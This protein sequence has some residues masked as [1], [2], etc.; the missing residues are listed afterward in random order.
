M[1]D[2][3]APAESGGARRSRL[4]A[5]REEEL[6]TAVLDL[7]REVGY[8]A[9]T[10][11]AVATRTRSSKATLYRQ[12]QGKPRLV[13]AALRHHKRFAL[14]GVDTGSLRG[15]LFEVARRIGAEPQRRDVALIRAL[16]QAVH[17]NEELARAMHETIIQPELEVVRRMLERAVRRGEIAPDNP[18]ADFVPHLI[19]GVTFARPVL[20]RV[21][22]DIPYLERFVDAVVLRALAPN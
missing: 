8:E 18:A 13:A 20:E 3:K 17:C 9:L 21:E 5:E 10:M 7:L 1:A 16:G 6:Y 11:D 4:T 2:P 15:D 12:W 19:A 22:A 14:G